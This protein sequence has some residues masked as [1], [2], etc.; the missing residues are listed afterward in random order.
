M[1][2]LSNHMVNKSAASAGQVAPSSL[3]KARG[4]QTRRRI[5]SV[6]K[7][8]RLRQRGFGH[9]VAFEDD[10]AG[11]AVGQIVIADRRDGDVELDGVDAG[12]EH[13][14]GGAAIENCLASCRQRGG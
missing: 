10:G 11:E 8:S 3:A 14:C 5:V 1:P 7:A 9:Q 2:T 4:V 12:P 6:L 13:A